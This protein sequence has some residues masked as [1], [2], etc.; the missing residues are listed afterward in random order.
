MTREVRVKIDCV[1]RVPGETLPAL[2]KPLDVV[3]KGV[4]ALGAIEILP[5]ARVRINYTRA[6]A[7]ELRR[8]SRGKR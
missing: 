1:I 6:Q 7:G 2:D 8:A 3:E 5:G 4:S